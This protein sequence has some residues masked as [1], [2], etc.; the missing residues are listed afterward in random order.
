MPNY[1]YSND[2]LACLVPAGDGGSISCE[3]A[4]VGGGGDMSRDYAQEY[5]RETEKLCHLGV[6]IDRE[7]KESFFARC[8]DDG[9]VPSQWIIEQIK[10]YINH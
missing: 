8:K 3:P 1:D 10:S 6:R 7:L 9:V 2:F 4:R 5:A